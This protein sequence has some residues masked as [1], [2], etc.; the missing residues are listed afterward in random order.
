MGK[1]C[2]VSIISHFKKVMKYWYTLQHENIVLSER[3]QTQKS[4]YSM[5]PLIWEAYHRQINI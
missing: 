5:N 3:R 4:T 1:E 2:Y